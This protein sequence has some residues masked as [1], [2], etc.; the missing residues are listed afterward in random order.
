[1]KQTLAVVARD[2]SGVIILAATTK[3]LIENPVVA[4]ALAMLWALQLAECYHFQ[5]C[6]I[7]GNAKNCINTCNE[8]LN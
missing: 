6:I 4:E 2:C 7:E 3:M 5:H 8:K 1:M